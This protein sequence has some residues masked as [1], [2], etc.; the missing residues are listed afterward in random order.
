[1]NQPLPSYPDYKPAGLPWLAQVPAHWE[2]KRNKYLFRERDA[3]SQT[4]AEELLTVSQY[5]GITK[6]ADRRKHTE[7]LLTTAASLVG[8]KLVDRHDL[9]INIMLAW[10]GSL[11]ISD[12]NGI[13][14]PAYC[15]YKPTSTDDP[16]YFH[17]L[18]RTPLYKAMYKAVSTGVV[19]SR[20]RLY[21]DK[22]FALPALLPPLP[23]QQRIVAFLDGKTRQ[24]ARLLRN[25]RQLIKLLTEQ[26]QALIHRAVTQGLDADA[27][28]KDSGVAWLGEVPAHWEVKR[29]RTLITNIEQGWS[30]QC[31]S[32]PAQ[33][34]QWGVLK[35]G[36]VNNSV[37]TI[38]ENKAL[39]AELIPIPEYEVQPGDLLMSRANTRE[40]VGSAALVRNTQ[41]KLLL[42]DKLYRIKLKDSILPEYAELF[43]NTKTTRWQIESVTSG[44]SSSMQNISQGV[45]R[46][47]IVFLPPQKEQQDIINYV[48]ND[49]DLIDQTITRAQREIELIQEYRTRLIADVV[50][51]RVDVRQL[52][53]LTCGEDEPADTGMELEDEETEEKLA[54]AE[55]DE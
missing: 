47:L 13:V 17:Y 28:R 27:P 2:V 29:F 34:G 21:S 40:L 23:E 9:V 36:C 35:V 20:L 15:V 33:E 42:C 41:S 12:F 55:A 6:R 4:G 5:T 30:P 7:E 16:R 45:V 19:D 53:D 11:G 22:F 31:E 49:T 8:Y 39:P 43:L 50:T 32:Q 51:G 18:F 1:M 37:F 52:A 54:E 46:D 3:R 10:N 24:I 48:Q 44:A 14:S 38:S 26:K 25:K